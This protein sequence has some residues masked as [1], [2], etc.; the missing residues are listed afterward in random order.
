MSVVGACSGT[1][2]SYPD[3][4][5]PA[6]AAPVR[7]GTQVNVPG[8]LALSIDELSRQVGPRRPLPA[9]FV[10]PLLLSLS[11]R[12]VPMDSST[13]FQSQ[14]I[15]MIAAYD[16]RTRRVS[17]LLLLGTDEDELMYRGRLELGAASYLVLPVFQ[18]QHPTKLMGLRILSIAPAATKPAAR[19]K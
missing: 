19:R 3:P 7:T 10:D 9:G 15:A 2:E 17:E 8:M 12:G 1:H 18:L 6:A 13:L 14:G 5:G 11:Q 16:D 4:P